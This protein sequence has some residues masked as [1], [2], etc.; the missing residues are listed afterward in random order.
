MLAI[1]M[2][3]ILAIIV[4]TVVIIMLIQIG[5]LGNRRYAKWMI[6]FGEYFLC[7]S[8]CLIF[9]VNTNI[10]GEFSNSDAYVT[11]ESLKEIAMQVDKIERRSNT[12]QLPA[13]ERVDIEPTLSKISD[14]EK[15]VES[16]DV[17]VN[18]ANKLIGS[19]SLCGTILIFS[20]KLIKQ[21]DEESE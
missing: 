13:Y 6:R 19:I 20:G 9:I 16:S 15:Q 17:Q 8:A 12:E 11:R 21:R 3:I 2:I 10:L 18:F 4:I 5:G 1:L 7:I 14:I